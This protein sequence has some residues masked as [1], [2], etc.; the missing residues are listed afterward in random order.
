MDS[1]IGEGK[2]H[3]SCHRLLTV[4]NLD[5]SVLPIRKSTTRIAEQDTTEPDSEP[6]ADPFAN[7]S[8]TLP[9]ASSDISFSRESLGAARVL[10]QVDRKFIPC[11]LKGHRRD[12]V[13]GAAS[14]TPHSV[15]VV[16]DQHAADERAAVERLLDSL[17]E[18]FAT[19]TMPTTAPA[20]D[21][22]IVLTQAEAE[23]LEAPGVRTVLA[24]WGIVLAAAESADEGEPM[25]P[26]A[27]SD[28]VQVSVT[29]V[30]VLLDR[31]GSK[32][33]TELTRLL[34]LYLPT[35]AEGGLGEIQALIESLEASASAAPDGN[36]DSPAEAADGW[37][38][39]QRWMPLEMLELAN[40]KACRGAIMFED[41]LDGD[42]AARL[43]ARLAAARNPWVCAHGRP[44]FVPL[45]VVPEA[46]KGKRKNGGRRRIDWGTWRRVADGVEE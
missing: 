34:R 31:L 18:G 43:V 19:D 13:D 40:S 24:R 6:E 21:V 41:K 4:Q 15:L 7:L 27:P 37:A 25:D 36:E 23:V 2:C 14:Q 44:T 9:P 12:L 20:H 29:A 38:R 16:F 11:V 10:A 39:V 30:P 22:R 5:D 32:R 3:D 28:Y 17:C 26:S 42:Q 1:V 8:P 46:E 45:C 33:G 35:L